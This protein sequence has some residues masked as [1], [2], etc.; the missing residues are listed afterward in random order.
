MYVERERLDLDVSN[1]ETN[2]LQC[3][4]DFVCQ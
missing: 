1:N 2:K 4:S 3:N